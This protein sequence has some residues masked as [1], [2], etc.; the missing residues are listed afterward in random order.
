MVRSK[1]QIFPSLRP[2]LGEA[3]E[4]AIMA[5]ERREFYRAV[6]GLHGVLNTS[7]DPLSN[8]QPVQIVEEQLY[9][10][11][12]D[13]AASRFDAAAKELLKFYLRTGDAATTFSY[14]I[15]TASGVA[16]YGLMPHHEAESRRQSDISAADPNRARIAG[17]D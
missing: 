11:L 17:F 15:C 2:D 5:S 4:L 12:L 7:L 10:P 8:G 1:R 3:A 13:F 6:V 16:A 14:S 9:P